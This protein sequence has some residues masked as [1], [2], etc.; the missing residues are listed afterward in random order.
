[1]NRHQLFSFWKTF[2]DIFAISLRLAA[3][4]ISVH[5]VAIIF[6][7]S[8]YEDIAWHYFLSDWR[9]RMRSVKDYCFYENKKNRRT[10]L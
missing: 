4:K 3:M 1:M 9:R 2:V 6:S 8:G 10:T 5:I 7:P